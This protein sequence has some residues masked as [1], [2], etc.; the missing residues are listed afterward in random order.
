MKKKLPSFKAVLFDW[1]NTLADNWYCVLNSINHVLTFFGQTPW[2]AEEGHARIRKSS[3][4]LFTELFGENNLKTA[5]HEFY[6][7]FQTNHLE[8][9]LPME[10]AEN[11]L[12][13][14]KEQ[15]IPLGIVSNKRGEYLRR[16]VHHLGW[17][18][19]F[20]VI[21]GAG[22]AAKDK[23]NPEPILLAIEKLSQQ[24]MEPVLPSDV[25]Y[26]GDTDTDMEAA[27]L[28][29]CIPVFIHTEKMQHIEKIFLNNETIFQ[30]NLVNGFLNTI[31]ERNTP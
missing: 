14:L 16:E 30:F 20:D 11:L 21:I 6:T 22:D 9:L 7:H 12:K 3:S 28:S 27:Q 13:T 1:D 5:L 8:A 2:S 24:A 15:N 10:N 25:L 29:G 17:G 23:P 18:D 31:K 4:D 26:V 19:Y